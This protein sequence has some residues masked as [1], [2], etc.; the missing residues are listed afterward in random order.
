[1]IWILLLIVAVL[2]ILFYAPT[3]EGMTNADLMK[4][5]KTFGTEGKKKKD[6]DA[7]SKQPIMGPYVPKVDTSGPAGTADGKTKQ[8]GI[9]P[10]IYGPEIKPVPGEA[11]K[12]HNETDESDPTAQFN[13]DLKN[14][15]PTDSSEPQPFLGSFK[16]FMH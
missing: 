5:L 13:P 8:T 7:E 2:V 1:M 14:A 10:D 15:F 11:P 3:R 6:P 12:T 9:Y 4:T 16:S